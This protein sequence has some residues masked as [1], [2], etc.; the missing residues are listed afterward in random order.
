MAL[1]SIYGSPYFNRS[2][3]AVLPLSLLTRALVQDIDPSG[4]S[5]D[6]KTDTLVHGYSA[7]MKRDVLLNLA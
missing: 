4:G 7:Y 3:R 2:V 5:S 6:D 1:S